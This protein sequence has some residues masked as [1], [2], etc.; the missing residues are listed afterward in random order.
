MENSIATISLSEYERLKKYSKQL[1]TL[2]E[3]R[4]IH[5]CRV[6]SHYPYYESDW[7][8]FTTDREIKAELKRLEK[9]IDGFIE[10]NKTL[11]QINREDEN[12]FEKKLEDKQNTITSLRFWN[13]FLYPLA[14]IWIVSIL[15]K[16]LSYYGLN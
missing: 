4:S 10:K 1:K 15:L 11:K 6:I 14:F 9:I 2:L 5:I 7:T 12:A 16:L 3:K 13:M 8:V